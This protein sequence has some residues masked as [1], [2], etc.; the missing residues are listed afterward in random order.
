M[1]KFFLIGGFVVAVLTACDKNNDNDVNSTD[2]NFV[3]Q[4]AMGNNAEVMAGQLAAQKGT[5]PAVKAFGQFMVDEHTMAQ[6]DLQINATTMGMTLPTG[7][8][9]EDQALMAR[10]N[11]LSG[12][13][14]DTAYIH[15]Q[16]M[17]HQKTIN[18][19]Q[20]ELNGGNNE[21]I[22]NYASRFLPHIQMHYQRA[23]SIS[24]SL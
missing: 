6:S 18:L 10:L 19:F 20:T 12:Y 8:P 21:S 23:D 24:R 9:P 7:I 1:K 22:R 14:F 15:S 11:S 5:N 3:N 2:Q 13:S 4:A 17:D 16:V